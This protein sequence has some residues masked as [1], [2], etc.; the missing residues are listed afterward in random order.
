MRRAKEYDMNEKSSK[1]TKNI[2]LWGGGGYH[3]YIHINKNTYNCAF[4]GLGFTCVY[5]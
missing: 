2:D 3:I 1:E 4:W 5:I